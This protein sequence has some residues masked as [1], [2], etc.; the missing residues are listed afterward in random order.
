VNVPSIQRELKAFIRRHG[1][2]FDHLASAETQILEMSALSVAA[3]HYERHGYGIEPK[4][5]I[6]GRFRVKLKSGY[7]DN[8][9]WYR[10]SRDG[11]AFQI[12]ANLG[13]QS[14]YQFDTGIYVVDVAVV[15]DDCVANRGPGKRDEWISNGALV[16]FLEAKKLVAFPMLLAQFVGI[17]HEIKP[18]FLLGRRPRG[19]IAADHFDPSLITVGHLARTAGAIRRGFSDR[20]F[21]IRVVTNFDAKISWLSRHD[22][23]ASPLAGD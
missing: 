5:L 13:V 23:S 22:D 7:K 14:A 16:T 10:V 18:R 1:T 3:T 17:V 8:F 19:F 2:S 9:S 20:R 4:N 6:N 11:L 12:H 21:R 15:K